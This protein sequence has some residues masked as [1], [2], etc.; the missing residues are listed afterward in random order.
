MHVQ[1]MRYDV[2]TSDGA[3]VWNNPDTATKNFIQYVWYA[4]K[5]GVYLFSDMGDA[6]GSDSGTNVH[7]LFGAIIVEKT[8]SEW[9]D[10]M[11][12]LQSVILCRQINQEILVLYCMGITGWHS[13]MIH[14]QGEFRCRVE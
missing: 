12:V 3:N 1:G 8:Q 7:G 10:P 2:L 14:F 13:L 6:R 5:E 11:N 4:E 9:F